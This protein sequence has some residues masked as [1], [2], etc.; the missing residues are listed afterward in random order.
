MLNN[1][2]NWDFV[3]VDTNT[4]CQICE[5]T[6]QQKMIVMNVGLKSKPGTENITHGTAHVKG[7]KCSV[8]KTKYAGEKWENG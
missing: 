2:N 5:K 8:C 7:L 4:Y 3:G 6:T 1:D